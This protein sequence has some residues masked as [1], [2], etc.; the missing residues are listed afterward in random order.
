[1]DAA[2]FVLEICEDESLKA[3]ETEPVAD[4][5]AVSPENAV[6]AIKWMKDMVGGSDGKLPINTSD[7]NPEGPDLNRHKTEAA[8]SLKEAMV[9]VFTVDSKW[10]STAIVQ[11]YRGV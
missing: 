10:E 11:S 3:A 5:W 4:W 2:N 7:M 9:N 1:M 8:I 6:V